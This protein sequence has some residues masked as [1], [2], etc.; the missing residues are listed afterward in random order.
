[1]LELNSFKRPQAREI[2]VRRILRLAKQTMLAGPRNFTYKTH[3]KSRANQYSHEKFQYQDHASILSAV[4][5]DG[6]AVIKN[7]VD[8]EAVDKV[9]QEFEIAVQSGNL[10]PVTRNLNAPGNGELLTPEEMSGGEAQISTLADQA[11]AKDPLVSCPSALPLTFSDRVVDIAYGF[12]GCQPAITDVSVIR[13]YLNDLAPDRFS[14]FHCDYQSSRFIKFF[15]YL[16]DVDMDGGPFC[17]VRGSQRDKPIGW[18]SDNQRT[19]E[20]VEKLYGADKLDYLVGNRGDMIIADVTGFHCGL[21]PQGR[22]RTVL[23]I[24]TGIHPIDAADTHVLDG[25]WLSK[26]SGKHLAMAD[27]LSP[28]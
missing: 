19:L 11:Y 4:A 26:M 2:S 5:T 17:Y 1:M 23:M 13:T 14:L 6:Y 20:E 24:N 9:L 28:V 8:P 22:Q 10:G 27:F 18:R 12:Y 16:N 15:Y 7:A 3:L 21:K 25:S